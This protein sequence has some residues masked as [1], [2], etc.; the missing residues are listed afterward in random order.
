LE[1][2]LAMHSQA[3]KEAKD[4]ADTQKADIE[5]KLGQVKLNLIQNAKPQDYVNLVDQIVPPQGANA[6]LNARTKAQVQFAVQRGDLEGAQNALK[7]A[8]AQIGAIEK[9]TN[10]AV[11]GA[12]VGQAVATEV[13]KVSCLARGGLLCRR[14]RPGE[15][16]SNADWSLNWRWRRGRSGGRSGCP[17]KDAAHGDCWSQSGGGMGQS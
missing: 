4:A 12:R 8:G 3:I 17:R 15:S 6:A 13:G 7:E 14:G 2:P 10:P 11:I 9:E 16:V 5:S 1:I